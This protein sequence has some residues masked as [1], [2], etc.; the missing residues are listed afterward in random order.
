MKVPA[1]AARAPLG[2]TQTATGTGEAR[3]SLMMARI[4]VSRPPGVSTRSTASW[5][6][7]LAARSRPRWT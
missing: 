4:E 1:L 2:P 6:P 3:M 5:A 7:A